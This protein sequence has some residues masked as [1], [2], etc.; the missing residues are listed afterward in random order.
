LVSTQKN[1]RW[2]AHW[3]QSQQH[4]FQMALADFPR[5]QSTFKLAAYHVGYPA[6][7][8][9]AVNALQMSK[10]MGGGIVKALFP[11]GFSRIW[12]SIARIRRST[13]KF[14]KY[15]QANLEVNHD[16]SG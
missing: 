13:A 7:W 11:Y 16:P 2:L 8:Y 15:C 5:C 1:I 3:P 9:R 6:Q 14:E 4:G 10:I 12:H